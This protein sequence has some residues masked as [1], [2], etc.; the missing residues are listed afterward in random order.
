VVLY[1]NYI[2][3]ALIY[4]WQNGGQWVIYEKSIYQ[5]A[6]DEPVSTNELIA[7]IA[8]STECKKRIWHWN[9][10]IINLFA[11]VGDKLHLPLNSERL[12]KLTENYVVSNAKI[13]Q[14]IGISNLPISAKDGLRKTIASFQT[15]KKRI[16]ITCL[17]ENN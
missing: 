5:V 14:A 8:E 16:I 10:S 2:E 15:H 9:K 6:D 17:F 4:F 7:L 1:L 13:K 12:Q 3:F 11:K